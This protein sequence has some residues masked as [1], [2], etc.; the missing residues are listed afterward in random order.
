M[1][2]WYAS[3]ALSAMV[4]IAL[5]TWYSN[6]AKPVTD[7]PAANVTVA[8][9]AAPKEI[10]ATTEAELAPVERP[11]TADD[12]IKEGLQSAQHAKALIEDFYASTQRWPASNEE[13]D[14]R[15]ASET[16]VDSLTS[17]AILQDGWI[18]LTFNELSGVSGAQVLF[19]PALDSATKKTQWKCFSAE[20]HHIARLSPSCQYTGS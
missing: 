4:L 18:M 19:K 20:F 8:N 17:L 9:I 5:A 14:I 13:L 3:I 15:P 6:R 16:G 2:R 1:N 11:K 7:A 10:M 12:H